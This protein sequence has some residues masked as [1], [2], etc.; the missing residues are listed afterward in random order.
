MISCEMSSSFP[1]VLVGAEKS[2]GSSG[3]RRELER[4][5]RVGSREMNDYGSSRR[6][7]VCDMHM[8]MFKF[9]SRISTAVWRIVIVIVIER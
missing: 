3:R 1:A 8:R 5:V 9:M 2:S 7:Q 6:Y 4:N